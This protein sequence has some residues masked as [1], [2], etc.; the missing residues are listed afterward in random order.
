MHA[1][2]QDV[3]YAMRSILKA[4][5]FAA[6]AILTIALGIGATTAIF[7]VV[8]ALLLRPLPYAHPERLVMVWQDLRARG[9]P[10]DEWATPGNYADWRRE[11]GIFQQIAVVTGWRPTLIANGEP[12]PL[13]GEQVSHEYFSVLG[14]SP[15]LGRNFAAGDDVPNARRVVLIGNGLWKRRFG[16]V[17]SAVGR[18]IA[19]G[20]EPHEIIGVLPAGFRPIIAS[21]AEIWRPLR[22]NTANPI[23][24]AVVLR[25]IARLPENTSL[26]RAQAAATD[27]AKRLEAMYPEFNE[28]TGFTLTPLQERV[29]GDVRPGLIAVFGAV[30]F[31]LLI[32]CVNIA[33]LLLARGSARGRE[34]AVR[35][36]LGASRQRVVRQ[37]LTESILLAACGGALG[38]LVSVWAVD[39]LVVLAP[40]NAPRV[41]EVGLDTTVFAF[42]ALLTM[43]T[44]VAFGLVPALQSSR[45]DVAHALNDAARGGAGVGG[46]AMRRA[47]VVSEI[48]LAL[49]LLTGGALLLETF[50]RLQSADLGFDPRDVLVGSVNPPRTTYDTRPK[51]IAF[52]DQVLEKAR[53]I[54]GV[55]KAALASVLPLSGDSDMNF[56]IEGRPA[57]TS[58]S[59]TPVTWYRLVSAGYFD[60]M[61]MRL[62]RGRVFVDR[63]AAPSVV[64]N[65]TF[66]RKYFPGEDPIGRRVR[67]SDDSPWSSIIGIIADA[68]ARGA[69]EA[70]KVEAFIPYWQFA[71]PGTVVIL[72]GP[73][74]ARFAAPLRAAVSSIDRAIPVSGI[75]TLSDMVGD[76][77][78]Q[79][80]FFATLAVAFAGLAVLLAAI[81]LYGVMAYSVSQQTTE[82]GVR[83]ALGAT[84][85]DVF[86]SVVRDGLRLTVMGL[87][88]GIVGSLLTARWLTLLLFGVKPGDPA[89]LAFA[90]AVLLAVSVCAC[91]WPARRATRVDPMVAIRSL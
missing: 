33:N 69:R 8:N 17:A 36:A 44:G 54:P 7:T 66:A 70:P 3:R 68:K 25:A 79:P 51:Y 9:G 65:E 71:E 28:K 89:T 53:A 27:L 88:L 64:V 23:R 80:R 13:P 43:V 39:G 14:V 91:L 42:A 24:G 19:L 50:V 74:P 55:Q 5:G 41:S 47:L 78:A 29:V 34:I 77:I 60:A 82:I 48:A 86:G 35:A 1:T 59:E 72:K 75:T 81:G 52:Y 10:P 62:R 85:R 83:M 16:G 90:G 21:A 11:P 30:G 37:L 32:A 67:F 20:G 15:M 31:V 84:R 73:N 49:T 76:S 46:R 63:E 87:L 40:A 26:D 38:V 56:S 58:Q 57:P 61:G 4:R 22:I 2:I 6:V 18:V 12:E 45:T